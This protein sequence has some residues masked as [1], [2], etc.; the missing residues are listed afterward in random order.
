M[1]AFFAAKISC[2]SSYAGTIPLTKFSGIPLSL[3]N[4]RQSAHNQLIFLKSANF[5]PIRPLISR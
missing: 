4:K 1:R 3:K 2:A 5:T